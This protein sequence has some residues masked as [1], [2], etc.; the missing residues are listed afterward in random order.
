MN[1]PHVQLEK[2]L[3]EVLKS[4]DDHVLDGFLQRDIHGE[5]PMKCSKQFLSKLDELVCRVRCGSAH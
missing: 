5:T 2:A 4:G 1:L 3:D